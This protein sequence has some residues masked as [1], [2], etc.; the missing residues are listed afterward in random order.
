M[1][2]RWSGAEQRLSQVYNV[3]ET[4]SEWSDLMWGGGVMT[5]PSGVP[6]CGWQGEL[7][8]PPQPLLTPADIAGLYE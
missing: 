3:E 2:F 7:C 8:L 6:S 4:P 1:L 5:V